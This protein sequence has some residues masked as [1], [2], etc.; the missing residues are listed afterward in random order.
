[1]QRI[2]FG[3]WIFKE[4]LKE[5]RNEGLWSLIPIAFVIGVCYFVKEK[6]LSWRERNEM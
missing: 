3:E 4:G 6:L 2:E 5:L 1:M